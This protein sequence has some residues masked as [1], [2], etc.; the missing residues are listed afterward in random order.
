MAKKKSEEDQFKEFC[1]VL[2]SSLSGRRAKYLYTGP[3]MGDAYTL[4]L[5]NGGDDMLMAYSSSEL[6][7]HIVQVNNPDDRKFLDKFWEETKIPRDEFYQVDTEVFLKAQKLGMLDSVVTTPDGTMRV[8]LGD[9]KGPSILGRYVSNYY[10]SIIFRNLYEDLLKLDDVYE[11]ETESTSGVPVEQKKEE[12]VTEEA[13]K[14][15]KHW[16]AQVDD[17]VQKPNQKHSTVYATQIFEIDL[18]E[19]AKGVT[20]QEVDTK[21]YLHRRTGEPLFVNKQE[22]IHIILLDGLDVV[23]LKELPKKLTGEKPCVKLLTWVSSGS[24]IRFVTVLE[25]ERLLVKS[26]RP[27]LCIFP[28]FKYTNPTASEGA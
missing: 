20:I 21:K 24:F 18:E 23:S 11:C 17:N 16:I 13:T 6:A 15:S 4:V 28:P 22:K 19:A 8:D 27:H 7:L 3:D 25:H 12:P 10:L 5:S 1:R 2:F 26:A 14:P 9:A